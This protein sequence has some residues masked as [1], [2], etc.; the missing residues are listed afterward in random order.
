MTNNSLINEW[1]T[2]IGLESS[3]MKYRDDV[4]YTYLHHKMLVNGILLVICACRP[5]ARLDA[6]CWTPAVSWIQKSASQF[7]VMSVIPSVIVRS[8]LVLWLKILPSELACECCWSRVTCMSFNVV[9]ES[10]MT[11][12]MT[13][14]TR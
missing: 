12:W 13:R 9:A 4:E 11:I 5:S 3:C 7:A 14:M 6:I 10:P 8:T 1:D 2:S